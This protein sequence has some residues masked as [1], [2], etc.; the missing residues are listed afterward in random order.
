MMLL[1][2]A[3]RSDSFEEGTNV[4]KVTA[5]RP[6]NWAAPLVRPG[7]ANCFQLTTNF[8]RGAQPS[9]QG[10]AALKAMG[11][12]TVINLRTFHSDA[13]KLAGTGL[14]KDRLKMEPWQVNDEEAVHFLKIVGDTNNLPVFVHCERGA[15]RTGTMCALYRIACCGW[16]KSEAIR[17]MKQGGFGFNPVWQNLVN[18]LEHA[19]VEELKRRAGWPDK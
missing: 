11:I 13:D 2:L 7:L 19:D 17:E 6:A 9:K 14:Q 1:L 18:Y 16:S 10:L 5:S 15:D 8:Y 12:K 3:A 4:S